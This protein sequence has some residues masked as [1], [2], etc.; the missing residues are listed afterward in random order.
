MTDAPLETLPPPPLHIGPLQCLIAAA[1]PPVLWG[2]MHATSDRSPI[3]TAGIIIA[4]AASLLWA[5]LYFWNGRRLMRHVRRIHQASG[6]SG[7]GLVDWFCLGL[8][9]APGAAALLAIFGLI[10]TL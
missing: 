4:A 10:Y 3:S 1:L 6:W 7:L 2:V 9:V 8:S 5:M